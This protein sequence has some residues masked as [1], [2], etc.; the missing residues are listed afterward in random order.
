MAELASRELLGYPGVF[1]ELHATRK[2]GCEVL[3]RE[4]GRTITLLPENGSEALSMFYHPFAYGYV[5]SDHA[6]SDDA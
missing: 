5:V 1:V 4:P 2:S 3:V 6:D